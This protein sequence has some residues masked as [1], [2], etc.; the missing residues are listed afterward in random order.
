VDEFL[1]SFL[2]ELRKIA[3]EVTVDPNVAAQTLAQTQK[4]P[5]RGPHP[6]LNLEALKTAAIGETLWRAA[7]SRLE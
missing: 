3:G 2:D 7:R 6:A 5:N 1:P 4:T